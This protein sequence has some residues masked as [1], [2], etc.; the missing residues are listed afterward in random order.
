MAAGDSASGGE[1]AASRSALDGGL[2]A[3]SGARAMRSASPERRTRTAA[4]VRSAREASQVLGD[5]VVAVDG[6]VVTRPKF[7]VGIMDVLSI[8]TTKEHYRMLVD[9]RGRLRL[10]PIDETAA[11][12]KLCRVEDKTTVRGGKVQVNLHDG[13]N[14]VLEK[15]AY[16]TGSVLKISVPTQQVLSEYPLAPGR[17]ALLIGGQNVGRI[18]HVER[19]EETRNPRA[20]VVHFR[21]GFST[22]VDKVFVIGAETPEVSVPAI[23]V[24]EASA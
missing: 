11:G 7:P 21:E 1:G 17:V 18:V 8:A 16:A 24:L 15:N 3:G 23:P 19:I 20:N 5:R 13:R 4:A 14:L 2:P 12:W 6:R 9:V 22:D 10:V